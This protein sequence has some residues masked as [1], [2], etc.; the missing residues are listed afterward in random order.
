ML[1]DSRRV[2]GIRLVSVPAVLAVA[3]GAVACNYSF[4]AGAGFPEHIRTVAILP[5]ENDTNPPRFE[6]TDEIHQLLMRE[7]PRALG[8][9][10][11]SEDVADAVVRGTIM[12]YDLTAPNYRQ[13][14]RGNAAQVLQRQVRLAIEVEI[15][16]L[17]ENV[18][19]FE[20]RGL[21]AEG[22]YLEASETEEIGRAEA[23]ELLVQKIVDGA[24]SNW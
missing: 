12:R 19:L 13:G 4:R 11:A 20:D 21:S 1:K 24:Q 3:L 22:Q 6:L 7:L 23:I 8:V 9:Q 17:Q 5:F 10:L 2:S 16:D 14:G 18:I 15:I